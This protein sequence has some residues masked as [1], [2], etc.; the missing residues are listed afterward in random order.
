MEGDKIPG[1]GEAIAQLLKVFRRDP[2]RYAKEI[3]ALKEEVMPLL[4]S[5]N[6][7]AEI[8]ATARKLQELTGGW[9]RK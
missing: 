2:Q 4:V 7:M 9:N 1:T 6:R 8:N 5:H 3:S